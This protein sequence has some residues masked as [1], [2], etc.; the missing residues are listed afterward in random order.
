[1]NIFVLD[2]DP[3]K[4]ARM[5]CDQHVLKMTVESAQ[6]LSA[7]HRIHHSPQERDVYRLTHANHP[8]S[9]WAR[10]SKQNYEWLLKHW[11][12]Q[13][14]EYEYRYGREHASGRLQPF[15]RKA[16]EGLGDCGLT[17]FVQAMPERYRAES[18]V[19]AYRDYYIA[20]KI[21]CKWRHRRRPPKWYKQ[22]REAPPRGELKPTFFQKEARP[23]NGVK[24]KPPG[25][26]ELPAS[27]LQ[28][29]HSDH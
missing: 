25:R 11:R 2:G 9:R 3:A 13:L 10:R 7:A 26:V 15:L 24:K 18:A 22:A 27:C 23:R 12:A 6:I 20:E 19:Q 17:P 29:R 14:R 21:F 8:C 4:A 1:V 16:P 5:L 28:G